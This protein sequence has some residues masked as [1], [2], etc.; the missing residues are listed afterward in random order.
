[1]KTLDYV[2]IFLGFTIV[3]LIS[4]TVYGG[5]SDHK[6]VRITG[7]E[8]EYLFDSSLDEQLVVH[9]PI[10]ETLISVNR[11][12]AHVVSAPCNNQICVLTGHIEKTGHWI[13]CLPNRVFISIES[14]TQIGIDARSY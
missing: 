10:G 9:G 6:Q 1:M 3:A 12:R 7:V 8:S 13:A 4:V 11:G 2:T 5:R 14:G